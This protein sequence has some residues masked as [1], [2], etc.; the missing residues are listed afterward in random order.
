MDMKLKNYI[1]EIL[2]IKI[3]YENQDYYFKE[4]ITWSDYQFF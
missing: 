4:G 1:S 2:E 3:C